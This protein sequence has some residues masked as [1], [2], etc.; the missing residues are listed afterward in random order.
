MNE[1]L[2]YV[3]DEKSL[4]K[5]QAWLDKNDS[6]SISYKAT[7]MKRH[8]KGESSWIPVGEVYYGEAYFAG[9][10]WTGEKCMTFGRG[11][12]NDRMWT[13]AVVSAKKLWFRNVWLIRTYNS[14]Y[15]LEINKK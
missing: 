4:A 3:V 13:S 12:T 9:H 10:P 11:L 15:R 6:D 1:E 2:P 7:K 5:L 14:I 8:R